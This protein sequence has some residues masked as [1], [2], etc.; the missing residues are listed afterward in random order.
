M[1]EVEVEA[2][3]PEP[4]QA[5]LAGLDHALAAG[6]VRIDLADQEHAL[7]EVPE[8]FADELLG[9]AL[10]VH[11]GGID[12]GHPELDPEPQRRD[13]PPRRPRSSPMRHVPWPRATTSSPPGILTRSAIAISSVDP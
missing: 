9:P 7:P 4:A 8:R 10:A 3:G 13:L 2:V 11:L 5:A 12:E 1:Q 6:V